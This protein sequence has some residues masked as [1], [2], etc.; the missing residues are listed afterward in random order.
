MTTLHHPVAVIGITRKYRPSDEIRGMRFGSSSSSQLNPTQIPCPVSFNIT[1]PSRV[2]MLGRQV[3]RAAAKVCTTILGIRK[4]YMLTWTMHTPWAIQQPA[5]RII[6]TGSVA[7]RSFAS[8]V[9]MVSLLAIHLDR[10]WRWEPITR[11]KYL[12]HEKLDSEWNRSC[13]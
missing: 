9:V 7:V 3:L 8:S 5:S 13:S 10:P 12:G 11:W 4:W 1:R 2:S 6:P